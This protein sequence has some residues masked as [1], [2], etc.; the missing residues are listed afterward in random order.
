[1]R[2][3]SVL[4]SFAAGAALAASPGWLQR[5]FAAAPCGPQQGLATLSAAY[6]RAQQSGKPLLVFVI[7]KE[8]GLQYDRGERFGEL[9]NWGAP[10]AMAALALCEVVCARMAEL[11][12][13]FP[14]LA[15]H[16]P[17][18]LLVE[19]DA[20]PA[21]TV[22]LELPEPAPAQ[23][24]EPEGSLELGAPAEQWEDRR[25]REEQKIDD[26]IAALGQVMREAIAKDEP[27]LARRAGQAQERLTRG[28]QADLR[29]V[30]D[31]ATDVAPEIVFRGAAVVALGA[32]RT[33]GK[34]AEQL[35]ELLATI[36]SEQL[37]KRR[38]PGSRW[39]SSTGC[40]VEI[41]GEDDQMMVACGMGHTPRKSQRFLYF[42]S[43]GPWDMS[44]E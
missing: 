11:R 3:R 33:S 23:V 25:R 27:M 17:A 28:E 5:A 6:R 39:A 44:G 20:L 14:R 2:R 40:G 41:E 24:V 36:A 13:L 43:K 9:L 35:T 31:G 10:E 34:R 4:K 29:R 1:M 19:T 12:T 22:A 16:E 32:A 38:V 21:R 15:E 37:R 42:F 7:P 18:M 30:V 8:R 26:R